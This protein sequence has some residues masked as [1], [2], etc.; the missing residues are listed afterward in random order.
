MLIPKM[1]PN[2]EIEKIKQ[3][4]KKVEAD[5][6]WE[7]SKTRKLIIALLTYIIITITFIILNIPKPFAN[8]VIPTL[9]FLLSTSTI[10]MFKHWWISNIYRK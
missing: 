10:P 7:T 2:K 9:A 5:K 6:A 8:A 1:T 3:R 4:N